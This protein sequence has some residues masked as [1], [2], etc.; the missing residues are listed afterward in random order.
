M[1]QQQIAKVEYSRESLILLRI[2]WFDQWQCGIQPSNHAEEATCCGAATVQSHRCGAAAGNAYTSHKLKM[3]TLVDTRTQARMY[4]RIRRA[5]MAAHSQTSALTYDTIT[6]AANNT[7]THCYWKMLA[8][9]HT[10]HTIT[11]HTP[12]FTHTHPH[13][14][15]LCGKGSRGRSWITYGTAGRIARKSPPASGGGGSR[16]MFRRGCHRQ[17][18]GTTPGRHLLRLR[19]V[20]ATKST[21]VTQQHPRRGAR[22]ASSKQILS[23]IA[24]AGVQKRGGGAQSKTSKARG[25]A[26]KS[27]KTLKPLKCLKSEGPPPPISNI[28][29]VSEF[30]KISE[31]G[32]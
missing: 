30:S 1:L 21:P 31:P 7:H 4:I 29:K 12:G 9:V 23:T 3:P 27:L 6:A 10:A 5:F 16:A 8:R 17:A 2:A 22:P 14:H 18:R 32:A 19:V 25:R 26:L 13:T 24:T 20:C 15:V 11:A 28:S